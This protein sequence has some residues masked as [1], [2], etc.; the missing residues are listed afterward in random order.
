MKK[1]LLSI[2]AL[3][4][5]VVSINAQ[6]VAYTLTPKAGSNNSYA[7][8]CDIA[9]IGAGH[10]GQCVLIGIQTADANAVARGKV[11]QFIL[12]GSAGQQQ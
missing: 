5:T 7:G 6:E 9:V 11:G 10:A 1:F 4:L 3:M 2:F 8:N 12:I